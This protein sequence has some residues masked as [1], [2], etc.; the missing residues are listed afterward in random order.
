VKVGSVLCGL[1]VKM[2]AWASHFPSPRAGG[3]GTKCEFIMTEMRPGMSEMISIA[4]G[5]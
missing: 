2:N 1:T 5:A 3:P 4:R